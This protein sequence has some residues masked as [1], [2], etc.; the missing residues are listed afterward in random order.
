M[1]TYEYKCTQCGNRI[2]YVWDIATYEEMR[3]RSPLCSCQIPGGHPMVRVFSFNIKPVM[4][5]HL[6]RTTGQLVS[7]ERQFKD[8]LKRQSEEA[9]IRT[10]IEHNFVPVD[11]SDKAT[12]GVT[13]AGLDATYNR[14]KELGMQIPDVIKPENMD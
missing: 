8:Q 11:A 9:T 2:S 7:S 13:N 12:L 3:K 1:P 10:G 6:N 14:R 4:Q 5:E